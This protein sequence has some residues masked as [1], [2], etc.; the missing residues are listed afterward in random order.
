MLQTITQTPKPQQVQVCTNDSAFTVLTNAQSLVAE[1]MLEQDPTASRYFAQI[2]NIY[3]SLTQAY[4]AHAEQDL[5]PVSAI[6]NAIVEHLVYTEDAGLFAE[7]VAHTDLAVI[8]IDDLVYL[9]N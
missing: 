2:A 6:T 8:N 1:C 3:A 9:S 5:V 4:Y 7:L